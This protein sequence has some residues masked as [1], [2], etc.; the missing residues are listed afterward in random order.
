MYNDFL[1]EVIAEETRI[2]K[3]RKP[4]YSNPIT[5]QRLKLKR[6]IESQSNEL[7]KDKGDIGLEY[8]QQNLAD[9]QRYVASKGEQ[10]FNNPVELSVQAQLLRKQDVNNVQ[11]VLGCNPQD[12]EVYLD[13]AESKAFEI[14]SSEADNFLGPLF[15]AIGGV[16]EKVADKQT[17]KRKQQGKKPGFWG[18]LSGSN[19]NETNSVGQD[20]TGVK[21]FANDVINAIK[22][23]EKKKEIGKMLPIII[24]VLVVIILIT[25]LITRNA[26]KNK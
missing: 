26:S 17:E 6:V 1:G 25:I 20:A 23:N 16:V 2:G 10:P 19:A 24:V 21:V 13:E 15:A 18:F 8:V 9:V 4:D 11:K 3:Q 7:G 14:N 5:K 12:A 22:E